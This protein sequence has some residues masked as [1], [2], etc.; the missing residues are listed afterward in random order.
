M[1]ADAS[2]RLG[3]L[4]DVLADIIEGMSLRKFEQAWDLLE[5]LKDRAAYINS[6]Q[7]TIAKKVIL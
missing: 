7:H 2:A 4:Y 1:F 3:P 6:I 5:E